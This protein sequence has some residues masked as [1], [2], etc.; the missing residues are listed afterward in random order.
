MGLGFSLSFHRKG[1][2]GNLEIF[3][4]S[5]S[6]REKGERCYKNRYSDTFCERT[7]AGIH[8]LRCLELLY[9]LW[10]SPLTGFSL[11]LPLLLLCTFHCFGAFQ[12]VFI[13][14]I[15]DSVDDVYLILREWLDAEWVQ[16]ISLWPWTPARCPPKLLSAGPLPWPWGNSSYNR[17][18]VGVADSEWLWEPLRDCHNGSRKT[19]AAACVRKMNARIQAVA[20][21]PGPPG[22]GFIQSHTLSF[23]ESIVNKH[24]LGWD[25]LFTANKSKTP[26]LGLSR[27]LFSKPHQTF[28]GGITS[29]STGQRVKPF[30]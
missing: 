23:V 19:V 17:P 14:L 25:I 20:L 28:K 15:H 27:S 7:V 24:G 8:H 11:S 10:L 30:F 18:I 12:V 29:P 13:G 4:F 22:P 3:H 1:R 5:R 16:G 21:A 9:L 6:I 26:S 2:E